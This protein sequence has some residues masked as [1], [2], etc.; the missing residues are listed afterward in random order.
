MR[1]ASAVAQRYYH[2][3]CVSGGLGPAQDVQGLAELPE[4][5]RVAIQA[6][7]DREGATKADFLEAKRRKVQEEGGA[8]QPLG[9]Q[10]PS[11]LVY[12][13]EEDWDD[14]RL[15]NLEWWDAVEYQRDIREY[16]PT[17]GS[18]P[19]TMV[20]G[21]AEARRAVLE[22]ARAVDTVEG[23]RALKLLFFLDRLLFAQ[24]SGLGSG[25]RSKPK[26]SIDAIIGVRLRK[27]WRGDWQA[28]WAEALSEGQGRGREMDAESEKTRLEAQVRRVEALLSEGEV[29]KAA[30]CVAKAGTGA[31][32][33]DVAGRLQ[34]W[35]QG[36]AQG[37]VD[38][39]HQ[40]S[41]EKIPSSVIIRS[42][43]LKLR[44]LGDAV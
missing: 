23:A 36:R 25:S 37:E 15:R 8:R 33:W 20:V 43:R 22:V 29:S 5:Q 12:N 14:E 40:G 21:V 35:R 38:A 17:I 30:G 34:T 7:C 10:A 4:R 39:R 9:G 32:G 28:L 44:A 13:L 6:F 1:P 26:S 11:G 24:P 16:V 18:V 3:R 31:S 41:V 27:F 42:K 2:P 19:P